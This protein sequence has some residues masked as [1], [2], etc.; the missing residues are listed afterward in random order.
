MTILALLSAVELLANSV[1]AVTALNG[2]A[3]LLRDSEKSQVSVGLKLLENDNLI[4]YADSKMQ[5]IFKD[6]T[7]VS[8]GKNS[9]FSIKDYLFEDSQE[10][11][12]NF[13]LL[14]G[15]MQT[16]TGKIGKIAP[17][18]F[19]VSTKTATI[20][21]RGTNFTV[22]LNEDNSLQVYC[23]YGEVMASYKDE[24]YGVKQGFSLLI[25]SNEAVE[26]KEFSPQ[27]LRDMRKNNFGSDKHK[28]SQL[29]R[30]ENVSQKLQESTTQ[31][32]MT[33]DN[34]TN[35]TLL[36]VTAD[37]ASD[38]L[39]S[40]TLDETIANYSMEN[41][42]Y[43]GNYQTSQNSSSLQNSG[44]VK[45]SINFNQET[46]KLEL[47]SFLEPTP[48]AAFGFTNVNSNT[49]SG[50]QIGG[51]GTANIEFYGPSGNLA[52]GEF[53]YQEDAQKS[54]TGSYSAQTFEALK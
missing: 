6:D 17:Q 16:I 48:S 34:M 1:A 50:T 51:Q 19:K 11:V 43:F 15:A 10:P 29:S 21:I 49:V 36:D 32:N 2:K 23:T 45:L 24:A 12:A 9:N 25:T 33:I 47:G 14:K 27:D 53:L 41:A 13:G 31:L 3:D 28:E 26:L 46:A 30:K 5:I 8:I 44:D 35:V 42:V 40:K 38:I 54:A 22:T 7:V 39:N 37:T 4:T 18:K 20:G 52:N